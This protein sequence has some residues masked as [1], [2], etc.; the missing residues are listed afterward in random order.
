M[1]RHHAAVPFCRHVANDIE[2][3][4][5]QEMARREQEKRE[6]EQEKKNNKRPAEAAAVPDARRRSAP[7]LGSVPF[8]D[9]DEYAAAAAPP[10][11]GE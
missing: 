3:L 7:V 10:P 8:A 11:Q 5:K 4:V 9:N 1:I 6:R 2:T